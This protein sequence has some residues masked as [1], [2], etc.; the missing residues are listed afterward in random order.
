MLRPVLGSGLVV[1]EGLGVG[2]VVVVPAPAA[3]KSYFHT[4]RP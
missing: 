3:A 1:G 2:V 4:L